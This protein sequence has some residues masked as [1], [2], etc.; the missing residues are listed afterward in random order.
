MSTRCVRDMDAGE[1]RAYVRALVRQRQQRSAV[2]YD[3]DEDDEDDDGMGRISGGSGAGGV[4]AA[5][6]AAAATSTT[7]MGVKKAAS[8]RYLEYEWKHRETRERARRTAASAAAATTT[9]TT[10]NTSGFGGDFGGGGGRRSSHGRKPPRLVDL[11][12]TRRV[13]L[14][15][16]HSREAVEAEAAARRAREETFAPRTHSG[17]DG[18]EGNPLE[19]L[20]APKTALWQR[21]ARVKAETDKL[22]F[23]EN[24]T[25]APKTGRGPKTPATKPASERLFAHAERKL[26]SRDRARA[27][28]AEME[29]ETLTFQ[30]ETRKNSK[31]REKVAKAPPLHARIDDV[32]RA[33]ENAMR[34]ARLQVES[35]R[36]QVFTF[37]PSINPTSVALA[38][39]RAEVEKEIGEETAAFRRKARAADALDE[40]LTFAPK[41]TSNSEHVVEKLTREGKLGA[42]FL[43]RQREYGE[44][45]SRRARRMGAMEDEECTFTPDIGNA[46]NVLRRGR[47]VRKLIET[48]EKRAERLAF[49]DAE[50]KRYA[51]HIREQT[52]YSQFT[53]EP[54][55]SEKSR[56]LAPRGT[57]LSELV[58]DERRNLARRRAQADQER[59][60]QQEHTFQPNLDR[61]C[62]AR[63]ARNASAYSMDYGVGGDA[64]SAR[65]EMY[66]REKNVA[67]ESLRKRAEY[68]ELEECT[69]RPETTVEPPRAMHVPSTS[70]VRGMDAFLQKQAKARQLEEEKRERF[71]KAFLEDLDDFDRRH[72]RT[73]PEPFTVAENVD[74]KAERRRKALA[75][76][77]LR[78][79]LEEC[80]FTP[81]TNSTRKATASGI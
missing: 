8:A 76:E 32:L 11:S 77:K 3:D 33:K 67:L 25:F 23:E 63:R 78:R 70:K 1:R 17:G 81:K 9:T 49:D 13:K 71:A 37:K 65:I 31:A 55:L 74:E 38:K 47:H 64:V 43:E 40:E 41:I 34:E 53:Y 50:K 28:L 10:T 66:Q 2:A 56:K 51:Q 4:K 61:S 79:E 6:A 60:F 42:G 36:A 39:Q 30:P 35:E 72:K 68:R 75:E 14:A 5:A 20:A 46:A 45:V 44:K 69:F 27:A 57:N 73:I 24:C 29:M 80:T 16:R 62:E 7:T 21:S 58:Y 26:A 15:G 19:K 12:P 48:P 22:E 18:T 52:Y 59:E 54:E